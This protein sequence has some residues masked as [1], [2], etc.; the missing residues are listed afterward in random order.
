MS[1]SPP[2]DYVKCFQCG[3]FRPVDATIEVETTIAT[4]SDV[5]RRVER[6]CSDRPWCDTQRQH[7]EGK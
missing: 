4:G 2:R 3:T 6:R 1:P 7:K 5:V